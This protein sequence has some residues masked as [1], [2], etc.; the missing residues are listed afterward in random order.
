MAVG[1]AKLDRDIAAFDVAGFT[2]AFPPRS[3]EMG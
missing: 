2:Q 1:E 3:Y